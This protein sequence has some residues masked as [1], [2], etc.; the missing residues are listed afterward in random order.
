[1]KKHQKRRPAP[2]RRTAPP[3]FSSSYEEVEAAVAASREKSRWRLAHKETRKKKK[4]QSRRRRVL[5]LI[6]AL[7]ALF[8]AF[9]WIPRLFFTDRPKLVPKERAQINK[10]ITDHLA[11]ANTTG[12]FLTRA[13]RRAD[14]KQLIDALESVPEAN[15]PGRANGQLKAQVEQSRKKVDQTDQDPAFMKLLS[16]LCKATGGACELVSLADYKKAEANIGHGYYEKTSPYAQAIEAPRVRDRYSR[17][18]PLEKDLTGKQPLLYQKGGYFI[19]SQ[20]SFE[21]GDVDSARKSLPGFLRQARQSGRLVIDLRGVQGASHSYWLEALAPS[22]TTGTE[23]VQTTLY[24]RQGYD[25]FIDYMALRERLAHL[26]L[27][28]ERDSLSY[29]VPESIRRKVSDLDYQKS[30]TCSFK[31]VGQ[32]FSKDRL[33]LLLDRHTAYAAESFADFCQNRGLATIIGEASPGKAW[34]IPPF[35]LTL[36]HSGFLIRMDMTVQQSLDGTNLTA[37]HPVRPDLPLR[38]SDLLEAFL[39][40]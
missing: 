7:A 10:A 14:L 1:M 3:A 27:Q 26:N 40:R 15:C 13:E 19:L 28:D 2:G 39:R 34:D 21:E 35:Y 5:R 22:L 23:T 4:K 17:L 16:D 20:L 33:F 18:I 9:Y 36:A 25:P 30:L 24:F 11:L 37:D 29:Q 31:G 12:R 32:A 6:P 38:G 8:L